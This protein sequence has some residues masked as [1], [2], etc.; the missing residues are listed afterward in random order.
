M[1]FHQFTCSI[2]SIF[3]DKA[4]LTTIWK[5]IE[6]FIGEYHI[7][8]YSGTVITFTV[9]RCVCF[10]TCLHMHYPRASRLNRKPVRRVMRIF[11]SQW[12]ILLLISFALPH[13]QN[14]IHLKWGRLS[15][16]ICPSVSILWGGRGKCMS[17]LYSEQEARK[18]ENIEK[19]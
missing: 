11:S 5:K 4:E 14:F 15:L 12:T 16:F 10:S 9:T 6:Y 18:D 17:R 1:A 3:V 2:Q 7:W 8:T 13:R 19:L